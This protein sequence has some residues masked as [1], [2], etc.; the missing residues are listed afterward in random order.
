MKAAVH[1]EE[2]AKASLDIVQKQL[3]AGQVNQ[4]AVLNCAADLSDGGRGSRA[5]RSQP[6]DR[7][8]RFVHGARRQLAGD[9]HHAGLAGMRDGRGCARKF[10]LA[11]NP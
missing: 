2:A 9:L 3:N 11:A 1:A 10:E 6:T 5:D 8:G 7:Y 4:L